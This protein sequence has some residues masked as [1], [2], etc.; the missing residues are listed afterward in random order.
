MG[1]SLDF[2]KT[3]IMMFGWYLPCFALVEAALDVLQAV[4]QECLVL[5]CW[6]QNKYIKVHTQLNLT[7]KLNN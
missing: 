5:G 1:F 7:S 2:R 6:N 3:Y 4:S